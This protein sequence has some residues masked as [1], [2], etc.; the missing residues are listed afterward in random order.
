MGQKYKAIPFDKKL[1]RDHGYRVAAWDF[2]RLAVPSQR[3]LIFIASDHGDK[4]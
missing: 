3:N 1:Q 2:K 4:M